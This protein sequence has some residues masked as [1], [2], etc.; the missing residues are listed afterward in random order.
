MTFLIII[1]CIF[2]SLTKKIH[3]AQVCNDDVARKN[4]NVKITQKE[5]AAVL[6]HQCKCA[7]VDS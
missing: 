2:S 7:F 3:F 1:M 5:F 6:K 4:A